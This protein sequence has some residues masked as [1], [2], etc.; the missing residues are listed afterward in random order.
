MLL[1]VLLLSGLAFAHHA[2]TGYD[3]TKTVTLEGT[4]TDIEWVNPHILIY[5]DVKN[6]KGTLDRWGCEFSS[7]SAVHSSF[8]WTDRTFKVGD[9]VS[10]TGDPRKDGGH[11]LWAHI[12]RDSQGHAVGMAKL[13]N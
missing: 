6:E 8:G 11:M 3:T 7:P 4:L 2:A 12:G 9:R 5:F 1:G 13:S 10:V